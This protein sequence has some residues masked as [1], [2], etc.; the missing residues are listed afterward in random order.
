MITETVT[1]S[2]L[3]QNFP[4]VSLKPCAI[5]S[6]SPQSCE[7]FHSGCQMG[8]ILHTQEDFGSKIIRSVND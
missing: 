5:L 3:L 7:L 4:P 1:M 8:L 6:S 2:E